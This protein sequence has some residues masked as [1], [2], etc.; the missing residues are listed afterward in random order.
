M[1][2]IL[3]KHIL[4]L[5]NISYKELPKIK[6]KFVGTDVHKL[7][8]DLFSLLNTYKNEISTAPSWCSIKK[9]TNNFELVHINSKTKNI[10]VANYDPISR[11]YFKLWEMI[12]DLNIIDL[13]QDKLDVGNIAEGPGG[14]VECIINM[15]KHFSDNHHKDKYTCMTLKSGQQDIPNWNSACNILNTN[16]ITITFGADN[17]G[18]IYYRKNI[19]F[20]NKLVKN[21]KLDLIT[22][23][24]G[25]DYSLDYNMQE[26]MSFRLIASETICALGSLKIGGSFVLKIFDISTEFSISIIYFLSLLFKNIYITKP[27][28]SRPAN[29]E[30]YLVCK[31]YNGIDDNYY[32]KLLLAL[33]DW[34]ILDKQGKTVT[35]IFDVKI[36]E[37][38][39][40]EISFYNRVFIK[41][42]I[43]KI[44]TTLCY[45]KMELD[46]NT[47]LE[48]KN[49]Q[50][51]YAYLWCT[52]YKTQVNYKCKYLK[53]IFD[54]N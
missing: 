6:L 33:D 32:N 16:N 50:A 48:I 35:N 53:D 37:Q 45:L 39:I 14:F 8:N 44:L 52:K 27:L 31:V 30:K 28:T 29:S 2:D 21:N 22:A 12:M 24:G 7:D 5:T 54:Y 13:N 42:Q 36:P 9:L 47:I 10:G 1:C 3:N 25:F 43:N 26:H 49:T 11:S 20:F 23:D 51:L 38:F 40:D 15:R 19:K 18:N 41:N 17:T 46:Y 34:E 4:K